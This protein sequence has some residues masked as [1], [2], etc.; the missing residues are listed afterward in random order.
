MVQLQK[1]NAEN[2]DW[3]IIRILWEIQNSCQKNRWQWN[4]SIIIWKNFPNRK[5]WCL[6]ADKTLSEFFN[7]SKT[8]V[9]RFLREFLKTS[10][11]KSSWLCLISFYF[12]MTAFKTFYA[13]DLAEDAKNGMLKSDSMLVSF[14]L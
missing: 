2:E 10:E 9:S 14:M 1:F 4:S 8:D 7:N 12:E 11:R 5:S 13:Y 3:A 6:S